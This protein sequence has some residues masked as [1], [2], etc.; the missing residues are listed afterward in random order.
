MQQRRRFLL[1]T[2]VVSETSRI[3][4]H[5]G[6]LAWL[7]AQPDHMFAISFSTSFEVKRGA[8][9]LAR[10]HPDKAY[11]LEQWFDEILATDILYIE[12][13]DTIARLLAKMTMVPALRGLW[14]PHLKKDEPTCGQDLAIAAT[15][16]V[17]GFTVATRDV[18]DFLMIDHYFP[19][20]GL[21]NPFTP[22]WIIHPDERQS[23]APPLYVEPT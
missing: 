10:T 23:P 9:R 12:E 18:A 5:R 13:G 16:I 2:N 21:V 3:R 22:A 7:I 14:V 11:A 8:E 19:L 20:P 1:D 6:L 17:H 15:A 4:P